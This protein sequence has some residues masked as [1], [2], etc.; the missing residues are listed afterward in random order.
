MTKE[1]NDF[2]E[3]HE[4]MVEQ[5]IKR[6][7]KYRNKLNDSAAQ[8]WKWNIDEKLWHTLREFI[9]IDVTEEKINLNE[10]SEIW[11]IAVLLDDK[12]LT[13]QTTLNLV[14]ISNKGNAIYINGNGIIEHIKVDKNL[15]QPII[16]KVLKDNIVTTVLVNL[17]WLICGTFQTP[18]DNL[19]NKILKVNHK[20]GKIRDCENNNLEWVLV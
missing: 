19:D 7:E 12:D 16:L 6:Y 9:S 1:Y 14:K 13:K 4:Y 18:P 5:F 11:K 8:R 10:D 3:L 17:D 15:D 20:N 2:D